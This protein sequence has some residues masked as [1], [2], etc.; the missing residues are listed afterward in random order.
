MPTAHFP[1]P[2]RVLHAGNATLIPM[3]GTTTPVKAPANP[4]PIRW[5]QFGGRFLIISVAVHLLFGAVAAYLVVQ[6]IQAKRKLTFQSGPKG[7]SAPMRALEHKVQMKK[8]Q[9]LSAPP[10][11]KRVTTSGLAKVSLPDMPAMPS[12][13]AALSPGAVSGM[14][15]AGLAPGALTGG[16]G[17]MGGKGG[18]AIN[19]FG[20]RTGG[21]GLPGTIYDLKQDR[22]RKPTGMT[23]DRYGTIIS[24]FARGGFNEAVFSPYFRGEK[25]LYATQIFVPRIDANGGPQAFGLENIIQPKMWCV[26]Y[27]GRVTAP[28][29]GTY[30]FVGAGD[31]V[32]IVRFDGRLVLD[33]GTGSFTSW[34]PQ[35]HYNYDFKHDAWYNARGHAVGDRMDVTAGSL[36][37]IEVLIGEQPGGFCLFNLFVEKEGATYAKDGKGNPIL[38]IFRLADSKVPAAPPGTAP[39]CLSD[40][41]IWKVEQVKTSLLDS[42]R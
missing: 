31:D 42:V 28:D 9:A 12:M 27:K 17:G 10:Q 6:T 4:R 20:A 18:A 34:K 14:G 35:Q 37:P 36:Y 21:A 29:S 16:L 8:Q 7:P 22:A 30:H 23:P 38:P 40:G 5:R 1:S 24:Q 32:L 33:N 26:L 13:T 25:P 19:F 39:P 11:A 41:P 2:A 15:A 3:I